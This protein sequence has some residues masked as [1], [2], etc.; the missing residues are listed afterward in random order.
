MRQYK[1]VRGLLKDPK[2][3]TKYNSAVD[4]AGNPCGNE[5]GVRFCLIGAINKVYPDYTENLKMMDK[6]RQAIF[7]EEGG[8]VAIT[9]FNDSKTTTHK[10]IIKI[11]NKAKI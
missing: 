10:D 1:T 3:W 7:K 11:L 2:R 6:L 9:T 8:W 5:D 4:K